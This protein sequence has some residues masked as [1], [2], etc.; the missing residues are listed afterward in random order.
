[1]KMT[2]R[3]RFRA[4][5]KRDAVP[6]LILIITLCI[7]E[8]CFAQRDEDRAIRSVQEYGSDLGGRENIGSVIDLYMIT[9]KPNSKVGVDIRGWF[10]FLVREREYVVV[11][12]YIE[13][14]L[15]EWKWEVSME[16]GK[17]KP[18]DSMA[19]GFMRMAEIF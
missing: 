16:D 6:I 8:I 2:S 10:S 17:I 3:Q 14:E 1:M 4:E 5:V 11:Y 18:L 12:A 19:K 9:Y 15:Y 13:K 7:S